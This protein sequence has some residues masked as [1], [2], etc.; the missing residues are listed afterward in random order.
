MFGSIEAAISY[1]KDRIEKFYF[2]GTG[3]FRQQADAQKLINALRARGESTIE[4]A[5]ILD[6]IN[7]RIE[8]W[9]ALEGMVRPFADF[10]SV[11]KFGLG[12]IPLLP[13]AL[14]ASAV[15]V[16]LALYNYFSGP[17]DFR[18]ALDLIAQEKLTPE[19]AR[20]IGLS[21]SLFAGVNQTL[22][23]AILGIGGFLLLYGGR[24]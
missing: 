7:S 8:S 1:I 19:E 4:A 20:G 15:T 6:Q 5:V 14:L 22:M 18:R 24:K 23:L 13:I 10:W 11:Q 21:T 12:A 3:L 17:S 9:R 16:A 2:D